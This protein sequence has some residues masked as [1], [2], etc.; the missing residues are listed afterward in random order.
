VTTTAAETT[1]LRD[2]VEEL[3][4]LTRRAGSEDERKAS[5]LLVDAFKRVGAR[6]EIDEVTFRDGYAALLM[7]LA[8]TG[9]I[10]GLRSSGGRR[11]PLSGLIA[12]AAAAALIDDVENG[13]RPY[14]KLVAK[15]KPTW[16]VVAEVGDPDATRTLAV[17]AHHDAAPTGQVFDPSFQR[18]LASR[19]PELIQRTDTSL[20]LWWPAVA[21]PALAS[22]GAL[23]GSKRLAR[24][25]VAF[26]A[27]N[28]VLG[29]DIARNRIVPGANDN[30]SGVA[31]L[32]ALAERLEREPV[33]GVRVLLA[34]CGAEE[35]L[36]GGIYGFVE[37]HLK[38]RDPSSTFVLNLDTIG[39]PQLVMLEGEGPFWMH[40][41]TDPSFRDLVAR[42]YE[43][44]TGTPL[45]R[46]LH[47]RASTDS[48]VP[49]RAGYPTATLVSW[50]PD[51]KLQTNYHLP[52]DLPE[53]VRYDT[54]AEAVDLA[55]AL[56]RELAS[57]SAGSATRTAG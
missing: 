42:V 14:R 25:G 39:S 52:T 48:I 53:H 35:V 11:R 38:P 54:V 46:G 17:I 40:D 26:A 44:T 50:E 36:Q 22:A 9:L 56:T 45:R 5:E 57:S 15:A 49:S 12:A 32:V 47:A 33:E 27:L 4:P 24:A 30:L 7:P 13:H 51:T 41:Y 6:A 19:F 2:V 18:W 1:L 23:T 16:N 29:A 8:A 34:S 10:V 31:A 43:R 28:L 20:P 55:E 37:N 3:A 21:G